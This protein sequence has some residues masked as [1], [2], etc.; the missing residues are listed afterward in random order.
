MLQKIT[1]H[2]FTKLVSNRIFFNL[3]WVPSWGR[4]LVMSLHRKAHTSNIA[5]GYAP[6]KV[7]RDLIHHQSEPNTILVC[8]EPSTMMGPNCQCFPQ[9]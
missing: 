1:I 4:H 6:R 3:L 5:E 9:T 8:H 7:P 2:S